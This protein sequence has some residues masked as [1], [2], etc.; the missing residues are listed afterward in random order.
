M[1][2][3]RTARPTSGGSASRHLGVGAWRAQT[4][5]AL[6]LLDRAARTRKSHARS[7]PVRPK[8]LAC[9]PRTRRPRRTDEHTRTAAAAPELCKPEQSQTRSGMLGWRPPHRICPPSRARTRTHPGT[10]GSGRY[11]RSGACVPA[12]RGCRSAARSLGRHDADRFCS[13]VTQVLKVRASYSSSLRCRGWG[14]RPLLGA[15]V[16]L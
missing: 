7:T 14:V 1:S 13:Q 15:T 12:R 9:A 6:C 4:H 3:T 11:H 16:L 8:A 5:A 10:G 2:T